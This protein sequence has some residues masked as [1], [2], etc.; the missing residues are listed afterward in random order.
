MVLHDMQAK[1]M[2]S[3]VA[4]QPLSGTALKAVVKRNPTSG[5]DFGMCTW[6]FTL[7][8]RRNGQMRNFITIHGL[9]LHGQGLRRNVI[10]KLVTS[11][12]KRYVDR[13]L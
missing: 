9:W 13:P 1:L 12:G 8:V 5:Q 6:F 10:Q 3:A 7:L 11:L 2:W 4:Q